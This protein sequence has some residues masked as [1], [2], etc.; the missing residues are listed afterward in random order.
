MQ[1]TD[2]VYQYACYQIEYSRDLLFECGRV[3]HQVHQGVIDRYR[4]QLNLDKIMP[5]FRWK[6]RPHNR[7]MAPRLERFQDGPTHDLTVFKIHFGKLSLKMYG[8]GPESCGLKRLPIMLKNCV[9]AKSL[10]NSR[11]CW[12]R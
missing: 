6:K 7:A 2:V 4:S 10:K 8:K 1:Y 5:L 3:L 9:A 12:Q 11:T